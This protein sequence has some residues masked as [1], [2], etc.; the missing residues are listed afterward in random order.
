M[1]PEAILNEHERACEQLH[2]CLLA[3]NQSVKRF[4]AFPP[5][6]L[7]EEKEA[8]T[9][10]LDASL[11]LLKQ[12]STLEDALRPKSELCHAKLMKIIYLAKENEQLL[13]NLTRLPRSDAQPKPASSAHL[14][15]AY[16][17]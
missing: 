6:S 9:K 4:S 2:V 16:G 11:Q 13:L 1:T 8:A 15:R 3:E 14:K 7:L 17:N 12:I 10:A 5:Q